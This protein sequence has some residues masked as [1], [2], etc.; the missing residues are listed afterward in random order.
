MILGGVILISLVVLGILW[1]GI[2][3]WINTEGTREGLCREISRW[4]GGE[5]S[6]QGLKIRRVLPLEVE[7]LELML[8][9]QTGQPILTAPRVLAS[10]DLWALL[11][12]KI[13]I[14]SITLEGVDL[15]PQLMGLF[16]GKRAVENPP[17]QG[18]PKIG[19]K[20]AR[21]DLST[22]GFV[23]L[24]IEDLDIALFRK[25]QH[26]L[27]MLI[28]SGKVVGWRQ[29]AWP[30]EIVGVM[31]K[32]GPWDFTLEVKGVALDYLRSLYAGLIEEAQ[33]SGRA[34]LKLRGRRPSSA[35]V[36][37][38]GEAF[39]EDFSIQWEGMLEE[40]YKSQIVQARARGA[41]LAD[42]WEVTE[43]SLDTKEFHLTGSFSGSNGGLNGEVSGGPFSFRE[44]IPHL[45]TGLIGKALQEFFRNDVLGGRAKGVTFRFS[46]DTSN[47]PLALL[48]RLP[49]DEASLRFDSHLPPLEG[50]S[51]VLYWKGDTVWFEELKGFYRSKPFHRVEAK[52]TEIGRVSLFEG[53]FSID[54]RWPELDELF[55]AVTDQKR[56]TGILSELEGS[57]ILDLKLKKAF[58]RNEPVQYEA[59]LWVREAKGRINSKGAAAW[60]AHSGHIRIGPD[61]M[62]ADGLKGT[63]GK[64]SWEGRGQMTNWSSPSREFAF[65][66]LLMGVGVD[67]VEW[68]EG[69]LQGVKIVP[70]TTVPILFLL[71]G[72]GGRM[73][74]SV[75]GDLT[76][77]VV[78]Y[79]DI[80]KKHTGEEFKVSARFQGSG[81]GRWL[82]EQA[83]FQDGQNPFKVIPLEQR[84]EEWVL[85][86]DAFPVEKLKSRTRLL[87][88]SIKGG[89]VDIRARFSSI[90][91]SDWEISLRPRM[92]EVSSGFLGVSLVLNSGSL[93]VASQGMKVESLELRLGE[94]DLY[95]AGF[96][97]KDPS[98]R[99]HIKGGVRG[100][101]LDLDSLLRG[102]AQNKNNQAPG[103]GRLWTEV[104]GASELGLAVRRM[105]FL[106]L[107]LEGIQ[108]RMERG[109]GPIFLKDCKGI[110]SGGKVNFTGEFHPDGSWEARGQLVDA[111]ASDLLAQLGMGEGIVEGNTSMDV[112]LRGA[113]GSEGESIIKGEIGLRVEKGII[114][115]FP[116][117]ASILSMM[118]LTQLLSGRLPEFSSEGMVFDRITGS[119]ILD[120]GIL[121]TEDFRVD[122]EAV[123]LTM[124][125]DIDLRSKQCDLKVGAQPFVGFD[126]LVGKV[127]IVRHYLAGPKKTTFATYFLVKGP[128]KAPEVT[129]IPFQ[130]MGEALMGI[131]L[132]LFQNP[133]R[134][135]GP[136]AEKIEEPL[137][138]DR[139]P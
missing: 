93:F 23:G 25:A 37:W 46:K 45:G 132:R 62:S 118:N 127:P 63:V 64:S 119:L 123:V 21:L 124:V 31:E 4:A 133:F 26:G 126:R 16:F 82:I 50:I 35:E 108:A 42:S 48:M 125:G 11:K 80:W 111:K 66:G 116:V 65:Q 102:K 83:L 101:Y 29:G 104:I 43:F 27:S 72:K 97:R 84:G 15:A 49:F 110:L 1:I 17:V 34:S 32:E 44:V 14:T 134:D 105:G 33:L 10:V 135:L 36:R 52:I 131:F 112:Q 73:G 57:A 24:K 30:F 53:D 115:K 22:L 81:E 12:G 139:S 109:D 8:K 128:L 122:S 76:G 86:A 54:L 120:G 20:G 28:S 47:G 98:G 89:S 41:V 51:G 6:L 39:V 71:E 58:L 92:V 99:Y 69:I 2:P 107:S 70:E 7:A 129:P 106:G 55:S 18:V 136:P 19:V 90:A 138:G 75:E 79:Q 9:D 94:S 13:L 85:I 3:W 91:P 95:F 114:R 68:L 40:P 38:E 61:K 56:R 96:V 74:L 113:K 88:D 117:L 121:H 137:P 100:E 5:A 103:D 77:A 78:S 67:I 60:R 130:S 87:G 59:E